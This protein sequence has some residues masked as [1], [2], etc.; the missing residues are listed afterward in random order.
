MIQKDGEPVAPTDS[1]NY[2]AVFDLSEF[3]QCEEYSVNLENK[4][5]D[6]SITLAANQE[7]GVITPVG[8]YSQSQEELN[9]DIKGTQMTW[10]GSECAESYIVTVTDNNDNTVFSQ[11]TN[12]S[13]GDMVTVDLE[14]IENCKDY[15]AEIK[16]IWKN[17]QL[18][19]GQFSAE[20]VSKPLE[21]LLDANNCRARSVNPKVESASL[22]LTPVSSAS[23]FENSVILLLV[24]SYAIYKVFKV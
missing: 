23:T 4:Y 20:V 16:T 13:S 10:A 9:L 5:H 11:T 18:P 2:R 14:N 7:I 19:S 21:K 3:R 12:S 6:G 22:K 8:D 1:S 24:S 15:T 17:V